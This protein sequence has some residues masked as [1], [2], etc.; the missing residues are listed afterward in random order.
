MARAEDQR[1][2]RAQTDRKRVE[3]YLPVDTL[4]ALDAQAAARGVTRAT[5]LGDL[6]ADA[7][8]APEASDRLPDAAADETP[9]ATDTGPAQAAESAS[10]PAPVD[11]PWIP[12]PETRIGYRYHRPTQPTEKDY[13]WIAVADDGTRIALRSDPVRF[14]RWSGFILDGSLYIRDAHAHT[15]DAIVNKLLGQ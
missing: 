2:W 3:V 1:R 7:T 10:Q 6:I 14:Y 4:D 13:D 8:P 9:A 12:E 5:V 15:R 11:R